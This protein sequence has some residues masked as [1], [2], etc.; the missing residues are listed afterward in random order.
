M[1]PC[2]IC[3]IL[4]TVSSSDVRSNSLAT[5]SNALLAAASSAL[6]PSAPLLPPPPPP[7]VEEED[8]DEIASV[9]LLNKFSALGGLNPVSE[10]AHAFNTALYTMALGRSPPSPSIYLSSILSKISSARSPHPLRPDL[11]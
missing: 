9:I 8:D 7:P 6:F 11:A 10:L 3:S 4:D 1:F 2:L 5:K